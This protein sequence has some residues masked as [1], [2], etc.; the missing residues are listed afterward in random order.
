MP[1]ASR[2]A[3]TPLVVDGIMYVTTANECHALD[4]GTGRRIWAY[5]RLR[6]KGLAGDA[7]G[8]TNR[9]VAVAGEQV[10]MVTDHAH[11]FALDRFTGA[12][13]WDTEMADWHPD[14]DGSER[15]GDNLYSDSMLALDPQTGRL[16]W[17][18][19]YTPH[20]IWDW[21]AHQPV[22]LTDAEWQGRPR[23]LLLHANRNGFFYV[24][25]RTNGQLL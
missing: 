15:R 23:K 6:T 17:H 5:R 7:A 1:N 2:L 18:F 11:I 20:D 24:L 4:A 8:G 12:L 25:D 14:Y 10:F 21:D 3:V 19:Q 16:K 13:R 22:V 9:G